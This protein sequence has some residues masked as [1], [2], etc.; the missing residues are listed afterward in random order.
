MYPTLIEETTNLIRDVDPWFIRERVPCEDYI[1]TAT[2]EVGTLVHLQSNTVTEPVSEVPFPSVGSQHRSSS[3][4]RDPRVG[5]VFC[6][7]QGGSLGVSDGV[8]NLD[9]S[10]RKDSR[11]KSESL[12]ELGCESR[13]VQQRLGPHPC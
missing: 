4:I 13:R 8:P 12:S 10:F 9:L 11:R 2:S 5:P 3:L 1:V 7:F 6:S